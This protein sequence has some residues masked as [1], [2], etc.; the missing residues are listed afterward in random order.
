M[1]SRGAYIA[2]SVITGLLM[3]VLGGLFIAKPGLSLATIILL[4]GIFVIVYG[5]ALVVMGLMGR[6]ESRGWSVAVG[7]LAV[8][9]GIVVFVWPGATSLAI[10]YVFAAWAL[11]SGIADIAHAFMSGLSGGQR[12]WLVIIGL[13]GIAVGIVFFVHPVS[14]IVAL[15]WVAGIYLI[16]LGVLRIIAGFMNPPSAG[17]AAA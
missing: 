2:L 12:V 14:G 10:L 16:V 15:L 11:I 1:Q 5:V 13:L 17:T 7:V 3:I 9:F 6:T 4:L 8:I